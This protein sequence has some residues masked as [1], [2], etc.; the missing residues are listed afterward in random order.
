M[1]LRGPN[2]MAWRARQLLP[3]PPPSR[4]ALRHEAAFDRLQR[5]ARGTGLT[6]VSYEAANIFVIEEPLLFTGDR[7]G[8]LYRQGSL[9]R[10]RSTP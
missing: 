10:L 2:S 1:G 9:D 5:L 7:P 6:I 3:E 4:A 8:Q